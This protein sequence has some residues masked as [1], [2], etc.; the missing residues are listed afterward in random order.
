MA[1]SVQFKEITKA[2][3]ILSDDTKR[4][5]YDEGGEEWF[6]GADGADDADDGNEDDPVV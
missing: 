5:L 3:E 4:K 2:Y 6:S 1:W